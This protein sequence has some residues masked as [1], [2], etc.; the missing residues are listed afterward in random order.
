MKDKN[1]I[2]GELYINNFHEKWESEKLNN[3]SF[4]TKYILFK[5]EIGVLNLALA[6]Y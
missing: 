5:E 4:M 3:S 1:Y 2:H 6:T